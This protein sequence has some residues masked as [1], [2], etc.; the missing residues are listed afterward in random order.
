[1]LVVKMGHNTSLWDNQS[2]W[3]T[4]SQARITK[5]MTKIRNGFIRELRLDSYF[6][7]INIDYVFILTE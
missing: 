2:I 6:N 7:I 3:D 4:L 1:M 5:K